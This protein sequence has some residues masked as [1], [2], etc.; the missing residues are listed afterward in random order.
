MPIESHEVSKEQ[1]ARILALEEG[2]FID[3]KALDIQPAKLTEH[4]AAFANADGGEL[5]IGIDE[6]KKASKRSW[7]GFANEEAAN[8]HLQIFERLFPLGTDFDYRFLYCLGNRGLVLQV[9][10]RKTAD[11][12][13]GSDSHVYIRRG[14]QKLRLTSDEEIQRLQYAK[15]I[16]SFESEM[17]QADKES[18]TNSAEIIDFMLQVIPSAEPEP[19]LRKQQLLRGDRPSV[20]GVLLFADD[21]Q[22]IVPKR[23]GVKIYRYKTSDTVGSRATL[24]FDPLTVEGSAIR[25]IRS[26][27]EQTIRVVEEAEDVGHS[28]T[29]KDCLPPRDDPRDRD[30]CSDPPRLQRRR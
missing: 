1:A 29:G 19:W 9:A 27:V 24:A 18:V 4:L 8:G 6:D 17:T 3:L 13:R 10:V 5:Y 28:G 15:G 21:P 22:A 2:H 12:K 25:Q 26:A 23:S 11:I 20:A 7:R 16:V 14:A 30:E